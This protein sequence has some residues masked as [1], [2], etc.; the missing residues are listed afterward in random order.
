MQSP[1]RRRDPESKTRSQHCRVFR[2]ETWT[3]PWSETTEG[4]FGGFGVETTFSDLTWVYRIS[5]R[6]PGQE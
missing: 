6:L 5:V 1:N 3:K 4:A 2:P